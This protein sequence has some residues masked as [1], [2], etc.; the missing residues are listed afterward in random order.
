MKMIKRLLVLCVTVC[1]AVTG[2]ILL[3][4]SKVSA[5]SPTF[6]RDVSR[7]LQ[8]K[9]QTCHHPGDI[10]PFSLM[11]YRDAKVWA[12]PMKTAV[13]N[14]VMPPWKPISGCG[15]F[16]DVR[17]LTDAEI[18]TITQ[19]VDTGAPEGDA[20]D[21]PAALNFQDGWSLGTPDM[22]IE[23]DQDYTPPKGSDMYRCFS[24]PTNLRG[25][26][27][28]TAID[29]R[30]GNKKLVH[31]VITYTDPD[32]ASKALDDADPGPGYTSFGGPGYTNFSM[33]GG[34]APGARPFFNP[35]G[36]GVKLTNN[37][38]IVFQVHYHP[39][40]TTTCGVG[41][42]GDDTDRTQIG[43][44]FARKPVTQNLYYLPLVNQSFA[45]P[46][47][48]NHYKVTASLNT[49]ID[50]HLVN[51]TP[52]MHL[53]GREIKVDVTPQG[54]TS[55]SCLVNITDW[56]FRWQGTYTY[57]NSVPISAGSKVQLTSYFDNSSANANNPNTPPKVVKWGEQT[58]DEMCLAFLGFTLDYESLVPSTPRLDDVNTD[59]NGKLVAR[60]AGLLPGADLLID[61]HR[62]SDST[63]SSGT[64]V[65]SSEL[66]KVFAP[67]GK[68]VSV[69]ILSPD[70]STS[71]SLSFTR[72]GSAMSGATV[73]AASYV[74]GDPVAPESI[75]AI[76]GTN[77]ATGQ[78]PAK[79]VPLP[80]VL[81]GSVVKVNGTP[82]QL[83]FAS[84][85]QINFL[86]PRDVQPGDA[87]IEVISADG[88]ITRSTLAVSKATPALFTSSSD[89]RGAPAANATPDGVVRYVVGNPDGSANPVGPLHYLELFGTGFRFAAYDTLKVKIG[90][91]DV[92]I[93]YSGAHGFFTGVDQ[94][95]VQV[96]A[97]V[98]GNVDLV[99][100]VDGKT[101]NTVKLFVH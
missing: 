19:W 83:F 56:D 44:Y 33:L 59:A 46:A 38:R 32:G 71:S 52:H 14:K 24:V 21:L 37:S 20:A 31:H 69:S 5:A 91:V 11:T 64:V 25:D 89:G 50:A 95:N 65:S 101:A 96:P 3:R 12:G 73:S 17:Q 13:T 45:I 62:V 9:C 66:W 98:T 74:P 100:Q 39:C 47:G 4:R 28:V 79:Q 92:P 84:R 63:D 78:E 55:T 70:G 15:N 77:L 7:I 27:F 87:M 82:A 99:L 41:N 23:A 86:M 94:L 49:P 1:L 34:W 10:A 93:L 72:P 80:T 54:S 29:V 75:G 58:T 36:I 67:P 18:A 85:Y 51:I 2:A 8:N 97:G 61:G 53:L 48:N 6:N 43:I 40:A 90:G 30:P 81:A 60:G 68:P 26:R 42:P 22:I 57:L 76:F 16:R 88:T 35:D